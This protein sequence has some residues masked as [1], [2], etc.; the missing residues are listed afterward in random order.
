MFLN[1]DPKR[2]CWHSILWKWNYHLKV[3][4]FMWNYHLK[5]KHF[6]WLVVSN[7]VLNWDNFQK[8]R[9]GKVL[10]VGCCVKTL[11]KQFHL[12]VSCSTMKQIW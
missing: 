1:V 3:K 12:I 4:H 5:V 7:Q 9:G 11:K 8:K 2:K 10:I 6:M